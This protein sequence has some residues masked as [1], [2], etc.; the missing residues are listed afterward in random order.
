MRERKNALP[1]ALLALLL[2]TGCGNGSAAAPVA[3]SSAAQ[4]AQTAAPAPEV[5]GVVTFQ[6]VDV[7]NEVLPPTQEE[8]LSAYDRACTAFGWFQL[9]TLP[10]GSSSAMVGTAVYQRVD[11]PGIA[12]LEQLRTY[13]RNLFSQAVIDRLMPPDAVLPQYRDIDGA[14]YVLPSSRQPDPAKGDAEVEVEQTAP[15][16][17]TV[18]VAVELLADGQ[19]TVSGEEYYSFPYQCVD[20]RWVFTNF[21]LVNAP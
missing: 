10:C 7:K 4:S 18:N 8:V 12:T 13:L 11:Y 1:A 14:L 2:L 19:E 15:N 6:A 16:T 17:W 9:N 3:A 5:S 21:K 20:G